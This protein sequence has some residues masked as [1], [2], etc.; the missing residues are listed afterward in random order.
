[1]I[2]PEEIRKCVAFVGCRK[3]V[4]PSL[5]GTAFFLARQADV[6]EPVFG[7]IYIVTAKHIIDYIRNQGCDKVLLRL[8]FTSGESG[9]VETQLKDW[10]FHP[11]TPETVDVAVYPFSSTI[12]ASGSM[13]PEI[14]NLDHR[15]YPIQSIAT[16]EVITREG[17]GPGEEV[18][19][20]G[21]FKHHFGSRK[22]IPIVRVGNIAAM[23]E[24]KVEISF[25]LIDAYLVESRSLGGL[26]GSPV[27]VH[28]GIVR[29]RE[30]QPKFSTVP[31]GIFYLLG[32]MHGHYDTAPSSS[33]DNLIVDSAQTAERINVGIG[34]VIPGWKILEVIEQPDVRKLEK[35]LV[36]KIRKERRPTP[37]NAMP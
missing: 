8:N 34:I 28:L 4:T 1:M 15:F 22:N 37:D 9:W 3:G 5:A 21:L 2:V 30:G 12:L 24:E 13:P 10:V 14:A 33:N 27:F 26:S 31:S 20:T 23:P 18:F 32:L 36:E 6:P 19:L 35:G 25:G 11:S 7:F 16:V 17:I 29:I